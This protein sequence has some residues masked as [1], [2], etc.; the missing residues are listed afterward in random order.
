M[1]TNI[2]NMGKRKNNLTQVINKRNDS[3][4]YHG[5]EEYLTDNVDKIKN[6]DYTTQRHHDQI[7]V[8]S[9]TRKTM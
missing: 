5:D 4:V 7:W 8:Y 1:I 6:R 2:K 3:L 9:E